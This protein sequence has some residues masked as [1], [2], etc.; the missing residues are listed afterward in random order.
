MR[1]GIIALV[2]FNGSPC[3]YLRLLCD[4]RGTLITIFLIFALWPSTFIATTLCPTLI[5]SVTSLVAIIALD[6]LSF[7]FLGLLFVGLRI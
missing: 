1:D 2:F 5:F 4:R 7:A 3:L 6:T